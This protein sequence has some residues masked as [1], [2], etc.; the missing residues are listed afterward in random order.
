MLIGLLDVLGKLVLAAV[1]VSR[2]RSVHDRAGAFDGVRTDHRP[3][4]EVVKVGGR[5]SGLVT[6]L[7]LAVWMVLP[8]SSASGF[9]TIDGGGQHREHERI[10]R[11]ALSCAGDAPSDVDCFQPGSIDFLAGHDREFGAVGAP[12]SDEIS[13]PAA[14]C[15][16]A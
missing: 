8:T 12:D 2:T 4:R 1:V 6:A 11:A 10:T 14:H 16:N 5:R 15:D 9:G 7:V 13:V 3:G